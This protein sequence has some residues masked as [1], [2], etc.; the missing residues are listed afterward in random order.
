MLEGGG[1]RPAAPLAGGGRPAAPLAVG[2]GLRRPGGGG[3]GPAA[4][5][6]RRGGGRARIR[7]AHFSYPAPRPADRPLIPAGARPDRAGGGMPWSGPRY[8]S[9]GRGV[10]AGGEFP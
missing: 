4:P 3:G 7:G 5:Q 9:A 8:S 2:G 1:G 10:L 6:W